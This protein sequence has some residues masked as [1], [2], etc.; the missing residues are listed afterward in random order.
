MFTVNIDCAISSLIN[1]C[2]DCATVIIL[3]PLWMFM[4]YETEIVFALSYVHKYHI[5]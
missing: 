1:T 3:I 4:Q 5:K 2:L